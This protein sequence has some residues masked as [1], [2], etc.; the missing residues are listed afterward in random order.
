MFIRFLVQVICLSALLI[1][2]IAS[3]QVPNKPLSVDASDGTELDRIV[4]DW[5]APSG[6]GTPT[7]YDVFRVTLTDFLASPVGCSGAALTTVAHPTTRVDDTTPTA[8]VSYVYS[9]RSRNASGTSTCSNVDTG[10]RKLGS[11]TNVTATQGTNPGGVNVSWTAPSGS[12][13]GYELYRDTS[14]NSC[15]VLINN[16]I[17]AGATSFLDATAVPGV[18]YYYS[19]RVVTADINN[20]TSDCSNE[21]NGFVKVLAPTNVSATDG[22]NENEVIVTWTAP[23]GTINSYNIYRSENDVAC[24]SLLQT[25]VSPNAPLQFSDSTAVP[26]TQ[27]YYSV[28]PVSSAGTGTCSATDDGHAKI[29]KPINIS[30]TDG[31]HNDKIVVTWQAPSAG[32][33]ITGYNLYRDTSASL[34]QTI[35]Q[36]GLAAGTNSFEDTTATPGVIYHYSIKTISPLGQSTCS[37][38]DS[39]FIAT[40]AKQVSGTVVSPTGA[41]VPGVQVSNGIDVVFT[42]ASGV[43]V[44]PAVFPG[45]YTITPVKTGYNFSPDG[46]SG[47]VTVTNADINNANFN[48]T[49]ATDYILS[50]ANLCIFKDGIPSVPTNVRASDGTSFDFV[51][52]EWSLTEGAVTY[53]IF[54]SISAT[55]QGTSVAT[56]VSG[57]SY[58]DTSAIPGKKYFYSVTAVNALAESS[59]SN[60]DEGFRADSS[61][62]GDSDGD[63]VS[64]AQED[65]DG[66]DNNDQGSFRLHLTSPAY[67]KF[68]TFISQ[69]AFLELTATGNKAV[70]VTVTVYNLDGTALNSTSVSVE[71]QQQIDIDVNKLV[72]I[73][74]TY[75]LLRLDFDDSETGAT[76]QGRMSIYRLNGDGTYSFAYARELRNATRGQ[77]YAISNSIDPQGIGYLVPNWAEIVNLDSVPRTFTYNLYR[78]SGEQISSKVITIPALGE[79]DIQAGHEHG[80]NV[81][82]NQFIP[83]DGATNYLAYVTRYS[84]NDFGGAEA[85]TYN[86]ASSTEARIGTGSNQFLFTSAKSS[87]CWV[88]TNWVEVVN[89]REVNVTA[90]LTFRDADGNTV[91]T[92]SVTLLPRSQYHFNASALLPQNSFG[93]V[94]V[95]SSHLEGLYVQSAIYYHDTCGSGLLQTAYIAQGQIAPRDV[96][97]G[98]YNT[99]I[100][101]TNQL[102]VVNISENNED[103]TLKL[104][105]LGAGEIF[106]G[107]QSLT[108]GQSLEVNLSDPG[109]FNTQ[110]NEVGTV[111]LQ[112]TDSEVIMTQN[113]RFREVNGIADFALPIIFQ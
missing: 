53:N 61:G 29:G 19:I 69:F 5:S 79:L 106:S 99:F 33:N 84:S 55:E 9:V 56:G 24:G 26:G 32:G 68:N 13:S 87:G 31:A 54:R 42:N 108:P 36:S 34:C 81:Y 86:Y 15:G 112:S 66:T 52:V 103:V 59:R 11:A 12:F 75:G 85:K 101:I 62:S 23:T 95:S 113:V 63:G 14:P 80:A 73:K 105:K 3:A 96:V 50:S 4:V 6:G 67:S 93:S 89:T 98:S 90:T 22:T 51:L 72:G 20:I 25:G 45:T 40:S 28:R 8:G 77:T 92:D 57:L 43:F 109:T 65:V 1:P 97:T 83:H 21:A 60:S 17:G 16:G 30:A 88:Q 64:D 58:Q 49:C 76:L 18:L 37:A 39:G 38:T 91:G 74:D 44:F 7:D 2:S 70:D 27:Y 110:S 35:L 47:S 102:R 10:F 111:V 48:S 107:D 41:P 82:L 100:G 78:Q 94:K 104:S 71:P 46:F